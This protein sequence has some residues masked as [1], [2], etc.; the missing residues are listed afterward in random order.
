MFFCWLFL[1]FSSHFM[2]L[3][4]PPYNQTYFTIN[5]VCSFKG[6]M[7]KSHDFFSFI[8]VV[9]LFCFYYLFVYLIQDKWL[10]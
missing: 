4:V 1:K 8:A 9:C 6:R 10:R 5:L 2:F 7:K 3:L